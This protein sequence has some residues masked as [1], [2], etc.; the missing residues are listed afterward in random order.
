MQQW[1]AMIVYHCMPLLLMLMLL[2]SFLFLHLSV[3]I[4]TYLNLSVLICTYLG[5]LIGHWIADRSIRFYY[6]DADHAQAFRVQRRLGV[7]HILVPALDLP[8]RR[9]TPH[10][11]V[12]P[13]QTFRV[14]R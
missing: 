8:G 7:S 5:L 9:V 2:L 1:H 13:T 3:L 12:N 6:Q 11:E 10:R 4:C 14:Q